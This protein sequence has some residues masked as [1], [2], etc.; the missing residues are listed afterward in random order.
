[1][2]CNE[3]VEIAVQDAIRIRAS[4]AAAKV[5]HLLVRM[6]NL[7]ADLVTPRCLLIWAL[8]L[9]HLFSVLLKL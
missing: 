1:M 2:C 5:F 8:E 9:A 6:Q 4:V 3:W 7:A